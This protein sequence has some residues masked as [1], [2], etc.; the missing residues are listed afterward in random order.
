[1]ASIMRRMLA[2]DESSR[3]EGRRSCSH[4]LVVFPEYSRPLPPSSRTSLVVHTTTV[5]TE[6]FAFRKLE[7]S[8]CSAIRVQPHVDP[9]AILPCR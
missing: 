9:D 8:R 6:E 7:E 5:S 3:D 4:E 2:V 1:M